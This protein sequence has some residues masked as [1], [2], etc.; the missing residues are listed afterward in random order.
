MKV[1]RNAVIGTVVLASFSAIGVALAAQLT[2]I[3]ICIKASQWGFL[4]AGA[5][6]PPVGVIHGI[7]HWFGAW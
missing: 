5:I 7:G 1:D 6:L 2:H 4:I 3:I